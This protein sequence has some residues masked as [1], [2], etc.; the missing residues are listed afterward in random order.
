M[1]IFN[2]MIIVFFNTHKIY[3]QTAGIIIN[4]TYGLLSSTQRT[5]HALC[6][7]TYRQEPL[8]APYIRPR[9]KTE[10]L[11]RAFRGCMKHKPLF[12]RKRK[13]RLNKISVR[14]C[15]R[16]VHNHDIR[17]FAAG[18][19][20]NHKATCVGIE[21]CYIIGIVKPCVCFGISYG[22]GIKLDT[23]YSFAFLRRLSRL[24]PC[25][26]MRQSRFRC[27]QDP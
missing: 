10:D 26:N 12:R 17:L 27:R 23:D 25:R 5:Q 1:H 20:I 21:K 22:I 3:H 18:S 13:H 2:N 9:R 8:C 4:I 7:G 11:S 14:A 24:Y 19:H 15:S 6:G 16:R